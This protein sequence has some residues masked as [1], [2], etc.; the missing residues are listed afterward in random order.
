MGTPFDGRITNTRTG[1]VIFHAI[2]TT[3]IASAVITA[4]AAG[5][6]LRD[7]DMTGADL[8]F[9]NLRGA[10]LRGADLR[11][12]DLRGVDLRGADL[13]VIR[14]DIFAVLD[15]APEEAL[16]V[17]DALKKGRVDG[18]LY[19]GPC[20]CLIGTIAKQRK[21][22]YGYMPGLKPDEQRPAER[23]F[24][25]ICPGDTPDNSQ[26]VKI[27]HDWVLEWIESTRAKSENEPRMTNKLSGR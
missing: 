26:I 8:R 13:T 9:A 25:A 16:A 19:E 22:H 1:A 2:G 24:L 17:A 27:T 7:A 21:C 11:G 10:D 20:C 18:S 14:A 4:L 3:D 5:A 6:D 23:W 12:A 15:R